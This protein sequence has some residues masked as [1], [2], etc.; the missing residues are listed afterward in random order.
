MHS[1]TARICALEFSATIT[2][3][4]EWLHANHPL[5]AHKVQIRGS[6]R[7]CSCDWRLRRLGEAEAFGPQSY[8]TQRTRQC[9]GSRAP[10][11]RR[12]AHSAMRQ[13]R[14]A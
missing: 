6:R 5:R 2:A 7:C 3:I 9:A 12:G 11:G 13:V 14:R 4:G 8:K 10:D 1:V